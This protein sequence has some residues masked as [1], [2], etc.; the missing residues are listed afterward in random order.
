MAIASSLR[1][2]SGAEVGRNSALKSLFQNIEMEKGHHQ[3]HFP[4]CN[5]ALVL[6]ALI[7]PHF[8]PLD[9]SSDQMLTW[10]T[11][12]LIAL[13]SGKCRGEIQ[14]FRTCLTTT[15][16]RLDTGDSPSRPI[17]HLK[18]AHFEQWPNVRAFMHYS[19]T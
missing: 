12:F 1:A 13:A 17:I 18:D 19:S 6:S 4:E 3:R 14:A 15:D 16:R 5:I 10:K 9:Q 7:K 2:T 11:V 8:E